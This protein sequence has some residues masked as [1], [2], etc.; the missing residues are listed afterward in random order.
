MGPKDRGD[1]DIVGAEST[2]G[3]GAVGDAG[4]W[5]DMVSGRVSG[6]EPMV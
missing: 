5:D 1:D 3:P 6:I 2:G 4:T